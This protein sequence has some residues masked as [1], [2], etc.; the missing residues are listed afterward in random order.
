MPTTTRQEN[1]AAPLDVES[2]DPMTVEE[3]A[4]QTTSALEGVSK[5]LRE[6]GRG[7]KRTQQAF[8]IF[9]AMALLIALANLIAVAAKLGSNEKTAATPTKAAAPAAAAKPAATLGRS[10]N[11]S[12][13]EFSINPSTSQAAAGKV[14]FKVHNAGTVPHEFVVIKTNKGAGQLLKGARA[15]ETGNVGETGDLRVGQSKTLKLNLKPG[16]YAFICNLPGHY[17]AGQHTDFTVK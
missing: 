3:L 16:H 2:R 5:E 1:G 10:A 4:A 17:K 8:T 13:K 11:V 12:L 7:I 14:T 15:D 6:Q 9:A